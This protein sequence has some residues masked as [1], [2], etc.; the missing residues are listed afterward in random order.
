MLFLLLPLFRVL[1]CFPF[2][3]VSFLLSC[4]A[5]F[6]QSLRFVMFLQF[7]LFVQFVDVFPAS[8]FFLLPPVLHVF[9]IFPVLYRFTRFRK[10]TRSFRFVPF[11][12]CCSFSQCVSFPVLPALAMLCHSMCLYSFSKLLASFVCLLF[13]TCSRRLP[14]SLWLC[15]SIFQFDPF[16]LFVRSSRLFSILPML[17]SFPRFVK[18]PQL[19]P[20]SHPNFF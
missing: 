13:C 12:K 1:P 7:V 18:F 6:T 19:F 9:P 20:F 10:F 3:A 11:C 16:F 2:C 17:C 5:R 8:R 15:F 14:F 4:F